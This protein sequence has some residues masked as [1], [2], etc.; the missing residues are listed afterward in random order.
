MAKKCTFCPHVSSS[1]QRL[2]RHI[3]EKHSDLGKERPKRFRCVPCGVEHSGKATMAAHMIKRHVEPIAQR[4][5]SN[6]LTQ[7]TQDRILVTPAA[8]PHITLNTEDQVTPASSPA[9]DQVTTPSGT[10]SESSSSLP[11]LPDFEIVQL[12][13]K[14][15]VAATTADV[16]S[17][18]TAAGP[19]PDK[20]QKCGI[21]GG[22][23]PN[24]SLHLRQAHGERNGLR[25]STCKSAL[26]G[27]GQA[28]PL[29]HKGREV[30]P[31]F[32]TGGTTFYSV[33]NVRTERTGWPDRRQTLFCFLAAL[34]ATSPVVT[35]AAS[36]PKGTSSLNWLWTSNK[37]PPYRRP[38]GRCTLPGDSSK[39]GK[40][41]ST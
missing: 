2:F 40:P 11:A 37:R 18:L 14:E 6:S 23:F 38:G 35:T 10:Q 7:S 16:T 17:S 30:F 12:G 8:L 36:R 33:L 27:L 25:R 1:G 20:Y 19:T 9:V 3:Q 29:G 39:V 13:G 4:M 22:L 32:M 28:T 21:Y 15:N 34:S 24:A 5:R 31:S 41:H 26:P